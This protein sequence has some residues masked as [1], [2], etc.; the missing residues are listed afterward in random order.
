MGDGARTK[1]GNQVT[2]I[3]SNQVTFLRASTNSLL[4]SLSKA[5]LL[6][7]QKVNWRWGGGDRARTWLWATFLASDLHQGTAQN[8]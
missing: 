8:P 1:R 3:L 6:N 5:E 7:Y 4:V 2:L